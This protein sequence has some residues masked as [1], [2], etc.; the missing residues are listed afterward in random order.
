MNNMLELPWNLVAA[1]VHEP[2]VSIGPTSGRLDSNPDLLQVIFVYARCLLHTLLERF[3]PH[4]MMRNPVPTSYRDWH[5]HD[6][7]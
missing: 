7:E 6:V 1:A 5:G 2:C 4:G 3:K